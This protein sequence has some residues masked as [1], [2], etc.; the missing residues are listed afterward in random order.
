[1]GFGLGN[2]D[3]WD[4]DHTIHLLPAAG[5]LQ[6]SQYLLKPRMALSVYLLLQGVDHF[7]KIQY[8]DGITYGELFLENEYDQLLKTSQAFNIL[9]SRGFVGNRACSL[10]QLHVQL[11]SSM[12]PTLVRDTRISWTSFGFCS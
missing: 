7:K 6:L 4:G 12:C 1:M 10:F 11:N 5:S 8:A 2:L 9:D 3:G